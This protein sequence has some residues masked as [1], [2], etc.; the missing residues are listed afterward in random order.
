MESLQKDQVL[1]K[2]GQSVFHYSHTFQ[3]HGPEEGG[4][5]TLLT[6][7]NS[8]AVGLID[9]GCLCK[10]LSEYTSHLKEDS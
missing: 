9:F 10:I 3:R 8:K 2:D 7:A 1:T 6:Y 5:P 4:T